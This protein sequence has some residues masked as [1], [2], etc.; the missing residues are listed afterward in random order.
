MGDSSTTESWLDITLTIDTQQDSSVLHWQVRG[1]VYIGQKIKIIEFSSVK[2]GRR[3]DWEGKSQYHPALQLAERGRATCSCLPSWLHD[4]KRLSM[5]L[6]SYDSSFS[7]Q[8][9]N[10]STTATC[11]YRCAAPYQIL[12]V[13]PTSLDHNRI[14]QL[15]NLVSTVINFDDPLLA[16]STTFTIQ[17]KS[18]HL[19]A[20]P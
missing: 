3:K 4:P 16:S 5:D 9:H 19:P 2:L 17:G 10:T 14:E 7:F 6:S 1:V 18:F 20:H 15:A 13:Y 11:L 12:Y 8:V